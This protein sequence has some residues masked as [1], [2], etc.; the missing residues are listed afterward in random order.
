VDRLKDYRAI[1]MIISVLFAL[2]TFFLDK[3]NGF[4]PLATFPTG[5]ISAVES[6]MYW[7]N[8]LEFFLPVS[9]FV[10]IFGYLV[11]LLFALAIFKSMKFIVQLIRG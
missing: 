6:Y 8:T 7:S 9:T 4:L 1:H 10:G 11:L 2:V 5:F 3:L